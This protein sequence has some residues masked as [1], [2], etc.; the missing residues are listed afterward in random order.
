MEA[1]G[2]MMDER[3]MRSGEDEQNLLFV[4]VFPGLET[5]LR[6]KS[7]KGKNHNKDNHEEKKLL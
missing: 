7:P 1:A 3:R 5:A 2:G 4:M 6:C